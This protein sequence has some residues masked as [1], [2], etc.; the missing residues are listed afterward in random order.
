MIRVL[1]VD[2]QQLVRMGL[3][4]LF[5][6]AR[7]IEILGEADNGAEAVR[8]AEHLAPDVVLMD[9]RMPGMDGITATRRIVAARPATR[10]VALTTFDDDDHLYPVLAAGA[11][12]FLVKDTPPAEL[13]EAVRR[14][15][16]GEAP[17]SRDVLDRLVAQA[18]RARSAADTPTE[19]P[20]PAITPRER[21]VLGLLG[22]GLSNKEI[23]DRLHLGVTTVKT[24]VAGLMAKTGRDNRIRLAVLAVLTGITPN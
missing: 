23:A 7:D 20:V 22:V 8:L 3:R 24:H 16:D 15:A 12:G 17:F 18:L 4:M 6:Q 13:L 21:E 2:D 14:A 10:V 5:E 11:C 19:I 9:L 1:V